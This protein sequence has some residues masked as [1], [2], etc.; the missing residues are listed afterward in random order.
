MDNTTMSQYGWVVV[1]I[2]V[3]TILLTFAS[4]LGNLIV[5]QTQHNAQ[6]LMESMHEV[7]EETT[8]IEKFLITVNYNFDDDNTKNYTKKLY[9]VKQE[10]F[11]IVTPEIEGYASDRYSISG[12]ADGDLTFTVNYLKLE[13]D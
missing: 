8:E 5:T 11:N 3:I 4:P 7:P 9:V 13:N 2:V 10:K 6:T 1:A 12:T